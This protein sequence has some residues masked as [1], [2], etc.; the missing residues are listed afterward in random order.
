MP[1]CFIAV[2]VVIYFLILSSLFYPN[3][4]EPKDVTIAKNNSRFTLHSVPLPLVFSF[5]PK[6]NTV[7]VCL[8]VKSTARR[9]CKLRA[10]TASNTN[11][12]GSSMSFFSVCGS[13][14][15]ARWRRCCWFLLLHSI[16][17]MRVAV[18]IGPVVFYFLIRKNQLVP[19]PTR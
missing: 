2:T 9:M 15:L 12:H 17:S 16:N 5:S 6:S 8:H 1:W 18:P 11:R 10:Y 3:A 4:R 19:P 7:T 13:T 14:L